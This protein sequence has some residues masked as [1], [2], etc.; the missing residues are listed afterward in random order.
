MTIRMYDQ[1]TVRLNN[2]DHNWDM[3]YKETELTI[4]VTV[5]MDR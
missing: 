5:R 3:C 2:Q 1:K 4:K